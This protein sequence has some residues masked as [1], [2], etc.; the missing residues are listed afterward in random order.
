MVQNSLLRE[1]LLCISLSLTH[2]H[3]VPVIGIY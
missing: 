3:I 2:L 1:A